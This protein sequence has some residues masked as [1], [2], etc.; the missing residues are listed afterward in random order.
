MEA[1]VR[2][3]WLALQAAAASYMLVTNRHRRNQAGVTPVG[4]ERWAP[5]DASAAQSSL[6]VCTGASRIV[7]EVQKY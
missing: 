5:P 2:A 3:P 6:Q 1:E 7:T 4:E